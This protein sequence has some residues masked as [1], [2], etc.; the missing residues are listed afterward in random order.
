MG[1]IL[2]TL[3]NDT[4]Q[5]INIRMSTL[6]QHRNDSTQDQNYKFDN[7]LEKV[8]HVNRKKT[9]NLQYDYTLKLNSICDLDPIHIILHFCM[10]W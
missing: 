2:I 10:V 8:N 6:S 9:V 3:Y 5:K 7:Q 1:M 4:G